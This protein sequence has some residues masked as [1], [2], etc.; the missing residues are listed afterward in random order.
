MYA[1]VV[2][3]ETPF[4]LLR[5]LLQLPALAASGCGDGSPCSRKIRE[6][7]AVRSVA[8]PG[9]TLAMLS[10]L[11][12]YFVCTCALCGLTRAR[13]FLSGKKVTRPLPDWQIRSSTRKK[14]SQDRTPHAFRSHA[15]PR[16]PHGNRADLLRGLSGVL[17]LPR[18]LSPFPLSPFVSRPCLSSLL[19][20]RIAAQSRRQ[21][22]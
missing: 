20:G 6:C 2:C 18:S 10:L 9:C 13:R 4:R 22:C 21:S 8:R 15:P 5:A 7:V 11:Y 12:C 16:F 17:L 19:L 3:G 14:P 1:D